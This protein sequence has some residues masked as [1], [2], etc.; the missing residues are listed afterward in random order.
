M[1]VGGHLLEDR[2]L[3]QGVGDAGDIGGFVHGSERTLPYFGLKLIDFFNFGGLD[4]IWLESRLPGVI[5]T[6]GFNDADEKLEGLVFRGDGW[7]GSVCVGRV[8]GF[9]VLCLLFLF[10]FLVF[11]SFLGTR[12]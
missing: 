4:H 6:L 11:D 3:D 12:Q 5:F 2:K 10:L 9:L 7:L 8:L 1:V